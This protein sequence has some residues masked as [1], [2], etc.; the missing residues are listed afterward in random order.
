MLSGIDEALG[1][2]SAGLIN[3][4]RIWQLANLI[5]HANFGTYD[6]GGF[7]ESSLRYELVVF[8]GISITHVNNIQIFSR[9][10]DGFD[11]RYQCLTDRAGGR[12]E[13]EQG[14]A[15]AGI[16]N[17]YRAPETVWRCNLRGRLANFHALIEHQCAGGGDS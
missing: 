10:A 4:H 5:G 3:Q 2:E 7:F 13:K 12:K 8:E 15:F 6:I 9:P 16:A 17:V 1:L 14:R 11:R